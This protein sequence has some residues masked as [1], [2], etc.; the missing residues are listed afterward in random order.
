MLWVIINICRLKY[1]FFTVSSFRNLKCLNK[2]CKS[3]A[4]NNKDTDVIA[5]KVA[6]NHSPPDKNEQEK[7]IFLHMMHRKMQRDKSLNFRSV[8]EEFCASN[9]EIETLVPLKTVINEMCLQGVMVPQVR[10]FQHFYNMIDKDECQKFQFTLSDV[11]FYQEKFKASDGSMAVVFANKET[12]DSVSD[13]KLMYVDASFNLGSKEPF[14]Y[15][16]MTVLVW[17]SQ[18]VSNILTIFIPD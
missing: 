1:L 3:V 5:V 16:L 12:I 4:T 9:P 14:D 15:H 6:H 17:V 8:Y 18:C 11:Q 10:S 7:Q 2:K 13:S